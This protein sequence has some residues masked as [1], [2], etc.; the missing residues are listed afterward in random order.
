MRMCEAMGIT[1]H[2]LL[3]LYDLKL[4]RVHI[5]ML[6]PLPM[7]T[8]HTVNLNRVQNAIK[9]SLDISGSLIGIFITVI[10]SILIIPAIKFDSDGPIFFKQR[11]VGRY[12]RV[13]YL[14]KFRTMCVDAE[15]K[16]VEL[17]ALNEHTD[18]LMFKIKEDPRIT[19]VGAFLRKTS[20][21]ELPQF[22]QVL[23]GDM[24]LVGTR[25]PTLDEVA[26]YHIEHLR[27]IS[28]KPGITGMWQV[29][30]RSNV[31]DF[32]DVVA[33]DTQYIDNWTIWLDFNILLRTVWQVM[34]RKNAY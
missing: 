4:S 16:K 22:F 27:R 10:V 33:L 5:S 26:Q 34:H 23:K 1:V 21:D 2:M 30:G 17:L 14:Y 24:S 8:F 25:P 31:R 18:G 15:A 29:N 11:R 13:F 20:L 19:R 28:I 6:G 7:L 9:R 32:E 12:G 3:K